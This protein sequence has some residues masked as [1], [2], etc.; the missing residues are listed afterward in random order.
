MSPFPRSLAAVVAAAFSTTLLVGPASATVP[1]PTYPTYAQH[2]SGSKV[3]L[4]KAHI[5]KVD[6]PAASG[7][8][9]TWV[10]V[11]GKHSSRFK[12]VKRR[13]YGTN[14]GVPGAPVHTVWTLRGRARGTATF[15]VVLRSSVDGD[16]ARRFTL[17]VHVVKAGR[18]IRHISA[19]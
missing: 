13:T 6:L 17:K 11:K 9:Y 19:S 12:I 14:A 8:A 3:R 1:P 5:L 7:T 16:V 4:E 2:D 10:V 15:K 18:N